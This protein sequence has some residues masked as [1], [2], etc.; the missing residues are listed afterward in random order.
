MV[1]N[2]GF[3][4]R[5]SKLANNVHVIMPPSYYRIESCHEGE[6]WQ[7]VARWSQDDPWPVSDIEINVLSSTVAYYFNMVKYA[8]TTDGGKNWS[9]FDLYSQSVADNVGKGG[10]GR[11]IRVKIDFAGTGKIYLQARDEKDGP[12][13]VIYKTTDFGVTWTLAKN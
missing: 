13:R 11:A 4:L 1:E 6:N 12:M 5:V 8:V 7:T 9:V 2:G 3:K 10:D